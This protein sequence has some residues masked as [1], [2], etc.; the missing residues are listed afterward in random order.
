MTNYLQIQGDPT[1]WWPV[2]PVEAAQLRGPT[3]SVAI[4]APLYG[5]LVISSRTATITLV[6]KP[7]VG[8]SV[9]SGADILVE[10]IY[11]PTATGPSPGSTGYELPAGTNLADLASEIAT[12]MSEGKS[13]AI[14]LGGAL[15]GGVLMLNGATLP[16]VVLAPVHESVLGEPSGGGS[17]PSG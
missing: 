12:L 13:Q 11:L 6:S 1:K 14:P 4:Q 9:P 5:T 15:S 3:L 17:V 2:Q 7:D 8:G 16:F 10:S